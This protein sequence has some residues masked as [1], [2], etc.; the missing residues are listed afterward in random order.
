VKR[1]HG[2]GYS[3][4]ALGRCRSELSLPP[5]DAPGPRLQLHQQEFQCAVTRCA[6]GCDSILTPLRCNEL[7]RCALHDAAALPAC[8]THAACM[9]ITGPAHGT[10]FVRCSD[11]SDDLAT[12]STSHAGALR[13]RDRLDAAACC[14]STDMTTH[15]AWQVVSRPVQCVHRVLQLRRASRSFP[16]RQ[17]VSVCSPHLHRRSRHLCCALVRRMQTVTSLVCWQV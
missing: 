1:E 9:C 2:Y 6:A 14:Q 15:C 7:H 5:S 13:C 17:Q 4:H 10:H 11:V 3:G 12:S 8:C 16:S